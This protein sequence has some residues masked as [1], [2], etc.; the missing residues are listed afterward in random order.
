MT[1]K[2]K[3]FLKTF[4]HS[5]FRYLWIALSTLGITACG[6][7]GG[8]CSPTY[9]VN[10]VGTLKNGTTSAIS[11]NVCAQGYHQQTY[12]M[13]IAAGDSLS[14]QW[15]SIRKTRERTGTD[16]ITGQCP[17]ANDATTPLAIKLLKE[18]M[19][20]YKVCYDESVTT[21]VWKTENCPANSVESTESCD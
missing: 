1:P 2:N 19:Q 8:V 6:I 13:E 3:Q 4:F 14:H 9:S 21:V 12:K 16:P 7:V 11:L 10:Y 15:N 18:D 17:K 5:K 20:T